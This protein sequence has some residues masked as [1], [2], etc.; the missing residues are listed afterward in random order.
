MI[1]PSRLHWLI[2]IGAALAVLNVMDF[3]N[4]PQKSGTSE[5]PTGM[6]SATSAEPVRSNEKINQAKKKRANIPDELIDIFA[7]MV[8]VK[9]VQQPRAPSKKVPPQR[10]PIVAAVPVVQTVV[11]ST[12][13][14]ALPVAPQVLGAI[15]RDTPLIVVANDSGGSTVAGKGTSIGNGWVVNA[16]DRNQ[17]VFLNQTTNQTVIVDLRTLWAGR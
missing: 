4:Q 9:V 11:A 8:E 17:C 2:A 12:T 5:T 1:R 3:T 15:E 13:T 10:P 7:S 6:R 14:T 16:L